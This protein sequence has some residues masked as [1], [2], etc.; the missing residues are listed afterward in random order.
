M[1]IRIE[2]HFKIDCFVGSTDLSQWY[3]QQWA[4]IN[5][6]KS[7]C[8]TGNHSTVEIP[9]KGTRDKITANIWG[10]QNKLAKN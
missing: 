7:W 9:Q 3:H 10:G 1:I 2:E 5:N 6:A 4:N 8:H